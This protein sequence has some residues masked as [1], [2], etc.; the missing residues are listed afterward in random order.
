MDIRF[1]LVE[2]DKR[3]DIYNN[4]SLITDCPLLL[5]EVRL[6]KQEGVM[7]NISRNLVIRICGTNYLRIIENAIKVGER[8]HNDESDNTIFEFPKEN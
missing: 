6:L 1:M 5:S 3:M 4:E 8:N 2:D 7:D